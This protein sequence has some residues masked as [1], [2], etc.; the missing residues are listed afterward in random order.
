[1]LKTGGYVDCGKLIEEGGCT[2][3]ASFCEGFRR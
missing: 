2:I 1:M 3:V